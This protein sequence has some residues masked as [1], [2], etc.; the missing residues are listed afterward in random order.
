MKADGEAIEVFNTVN[1]LGSLTVD[2]EG[3]SQDIKRRL[4]KAR[5]SAIA[6]TNIWKDRG[7]SRATKINIMDT[8]VFPITTYGSET[9]AVGRTDRSKIQAFEIWC[10]RKMSKISRK[11]HKTNEFEKKSDVFDTICIVSF[12]EFVYNSSTKMT[13]YTK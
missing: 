10:C 2:R 4:A 9:W 11:E 6:L 3:S 7:A 12:T 8:L 1:L 5:T 13:M